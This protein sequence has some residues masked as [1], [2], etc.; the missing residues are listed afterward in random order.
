MARLLF[1]TRAQQG[2][3][4]FSPGTT[5]ASAEMNPPRIERTESIEP[6]TYPIRRDRA[7]PCRAVRKSIPRDAAMTATWLCAQRLTVDSV[8]AIL[9]QAATAAECVL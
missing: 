3:E 7:V 6:V 2:P 1:L 9:S 5:T 4:T 8:N